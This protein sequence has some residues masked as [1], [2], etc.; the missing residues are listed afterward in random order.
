MGTHFSDG[1]E[2]TCFWPSRGCIPPPFPPCPCV[3]SPQTKGYLS[4]SRGEPTKES[5]LLNIT[6][7]KRVYF[8][9]VKYR[10]MYYSKVKHMCL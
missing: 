5:H 3:G 1:G 2:G 4:H 7:I 9:G 8:I 6:T 10:Y